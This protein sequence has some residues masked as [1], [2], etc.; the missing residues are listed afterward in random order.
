M[1]AYACQVYCDRGSVVIHQ[2]HSIP[3]NDF[4]DEP[5]LNAAIIAQWHNE[6]CLSDVRSFPEAGNGQK[7]SSASKN[8]NDQTQ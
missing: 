2:L 7:P 6:D 1:L 4:Q 3:T 8:K 5:A